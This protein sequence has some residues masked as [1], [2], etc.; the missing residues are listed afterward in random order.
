[1]LAPGAHLEPRS[2]AALLARRIE[3]LPTARLALVAGLRKKSPAAKLLDR[4]ARHDNA[5]T[6]DAFFLTSH[7]PRHQLLALIRALAPRRLALVHGR[8]R[9]LEHLGRAIV[10]DG[11]RGEVLIPD[12]GDTV[13]VP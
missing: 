4:A 1:M 3:A 12:N 2:P 5:P 6:A 9:A 13:E 8:A 10:Q 11:Y 7:A